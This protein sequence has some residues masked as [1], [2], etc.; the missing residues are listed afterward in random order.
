MEKGKIL[1]RWKEYVGELYNDNRGP[2]PTIYKNMGSPKILQSEVRYAVQ[3]MKNGKAVRPDKIAIEM[4][5]ALEEFGISKL[6]EVKNQIYESGNFPEELMKS[7]FTIIPKKNGATECEQHRTISI[8]SHIT[9]IILIV[10]MTRAK[11]EI[12]LRTGRE[13]CG[14]VQ[15]SGTSNAIF[16]LRT[17]GERSVE[18]QK[19]LYVCFLD[20]SKAFDTIK[21]EILLEIV[22]SMD[23]YGKDIRLLRNLYWDQTAA[24]KVGQ[25]T[26]DFSP[27]KRGVRQGD[28]YSPDLFKIYSK[29]IFDE[30]EDMPGVIVGG[31][32]TNNLRF[33]DDG[34]LIATSEEEL[35]DLL[36]TVDQASLE[37]GLHLNITKTKC[38]VITKK[39]DIPN[40]NIWL[41][42][43]PEPLGDGETPRH[44]L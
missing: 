12:K 40:C 10:L 11:E 19:D 14:F 16:M 42:N 39:N 29:P 4:I 22:Q 15:D 34:V 17:L 41:N 38:M 35:Q 37:R 25:E 43:K 23:I 36:D 9:K 18:V 44:M 1:E 8:M 24:V 33:A 26:S 3:R 20:Y 27:I 6:T 7:I 32:N 30:I 2:K 21:H 28:N 5:K 13:Q 31:T